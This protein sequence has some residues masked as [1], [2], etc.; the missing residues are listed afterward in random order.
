[1]DPLLAK[2]VDG[3]TNLGDS[4]ILLPLSVGVFLWLLAFCSRQAAGAWAV[5]MLAAVV[6]IA[7]L[8]F[9]LQTCDSL[10]RLRLV[11][12]SGH[13]AFGTAVYGAIAMLVARQK[14]GWTGLAVTVAA[15]VIVGICVTRLLIGVHSQAEVLVGL[16]IGAGALLVF[17]H[18]LRRSPP[19]TID[20]WRIA[21]VLGPACAVILAWMLYHDWGFSP[22]GAIREVALGLGAATFQCAPQVPE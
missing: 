3:V 19:F 13:A 21:L 15:L 8:K 16:A 7:I 5:A 20:F 6:P 9:A 12:P 10:D 14:P 18:H 22:N 2:A 11:T 4:A 1:M 17:R